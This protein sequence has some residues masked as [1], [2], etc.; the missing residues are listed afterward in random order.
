VQAK[1][2]AAFQRS[3]Q[4]DARRVKLTVQDSSVTLTGNVRSWAERREAETAAWA[5]PGV[6]HLD[7]LLAVV[8]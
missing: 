6:A 8:P 3:A 1:I 5:A 4:I 2:E 7:E